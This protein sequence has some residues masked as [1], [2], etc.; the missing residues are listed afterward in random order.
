M[1]LG[2]KLEEFHNSFS[3]LLSHRSRL[4]LKDSSYVTGKRNDGENMARKLSFLL[5]MR[6]R[7]VKLVVRVQTESTSSR[8]LNSESLS[9]DKFLQ[10]QRS[11]RYWLNDSSLYLHNHNFPFRSPFCAYLQFSP[12]LLLSP[13]RSERANQKIVYSIGMCP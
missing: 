5:C 10:I 11:W 9:G 3:Y 7:H 2:N 6:A 1:R 13:P 12:L 4:L 8:R